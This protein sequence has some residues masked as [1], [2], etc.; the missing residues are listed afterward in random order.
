M[1]IDEE[2]AKLT[3]QAWFEAPV[4][5]F[6]NPSG[7]WFAH[8]GYRELED[9]DGQGESPEAAFQALLAFCEEA[10]QPV[11]YDPHGIG[12]RCF[13]C[14]FETCPTGLLAQ[15][16][17]RRG[18]PVPSVWDACICNRERHPLCPAHPAQV[19]PQPGPC[20]RCDEHG[21]P[22]PSCG[23]PICEACRTP[24]YGLDGALPECESRGQ[25]R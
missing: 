13:S 14:C 2:N 23:E 24:H 8:V 22:C 25:G 19:E 20:V 1:G 6:Q 5:F 9:L 4:R 12:T 16:L 18:V 10:G 7:K 21:E 17:R 15:E 3:R 11:R